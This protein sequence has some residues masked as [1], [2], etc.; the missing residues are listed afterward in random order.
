M[1]CEHVCKVL[2]KYVDRFLI[3]RLCVKFTQT[4]HKRQVQS[5]FRLENKKNTFKLSLELLFSGM[6]K[7][8]QKLINPKLI[9]IP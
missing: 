2:G 6:Q 3:Y 8:L 1:A 4:V 9:Q 7:I 5:T